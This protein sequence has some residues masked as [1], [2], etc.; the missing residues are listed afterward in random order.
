MIFSKISFLNN[1]AMSKENFDIFQ[2][3]FLLN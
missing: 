3:M 2:E 1:I